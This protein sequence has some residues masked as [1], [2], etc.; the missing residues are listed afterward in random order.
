MS[1]ID[2]LRAKRGQ[3]KEITAL[4][5][6]ETALSMA[7]GMG[8]AFAGAVAGAAEVVRTGDIFE[9]T[10]AFESVAEATNNV[11]MYQPRTDGGKAA[12]KAV[13]DLYQEYITETGE[14]WGEDTL[15]A[16]GSPLLAAA[17]R[18]T[19]DALA[20]LLPLTLRPVGKGIKRTGKAA[21]NRATQKLAAKKPGALEAYVDI[22]TGEPV[23][24]DPI[25]YPIHDK[26]VS[27][28]ALRSFLKSESGVPHDGVKALIKPIAFK[29]VEVLRDW[30]SPTLTQVADSIFRPS[31]ADKS[32]GYKGVDLIESMGRAEG[33]LQKAFDEIITPIKGRFK[34][35]PKEA[36]L[37]LVR[38]LRTGKV[39]E[40]YAPEAMKMREFLDT[41]IDTYVR[42]V[43]ETPE[44]PISYLENYFPQVWD[45]NRIQ[46]APGKFREFVT[47][48]LGYSQEAAE[49]FMRRVVEN[50]GSPE[51]AFESARLTNAAD[52][53]AWAR[54]VRQPGGA[55]KSGNLEMQR[56]VEIP[57]EILPFAE[58]WLLNDLQGVM[59][60]YIR[61]ITRRV[62]YARTMGRSEGKLNRAVS[63][64]I[65]ELG[66]ENNIKAVEQLTSDVYGLA[67]ALQGKYRPIKSLSLAKWNRRL[68]NYETVLH[69][70]L[71]SLASFPEFTA[72]AIQFGFVPRAYARGV[73][74]AAN[75]AA[76][77][78]QRVLTGKRTLKKLREAEALEDAGAISMNVLQSSQ[79]SRF[80]NV[81]SR[82]TSRF[83]HLT[84]LE[85]LTDTQRVIA[86]ATIEKVIQKNAKKIAEGKS[87]PHNKGLLEELGLNPKEVVEWYKQG[88]PEGYIA[89]MV[90]NA[91]I[92]AQ[93]WAITAPNPA[94]KPLLF[95]DPHWTNV[96]LF[97]SFTSVFSNVFMKRALSELGIKWQDIKSPISAKARIIGGMVAAI[98]IAYYTQFLR[99]LI[100][101][102]E[103]DADTGERLLQAFDRAALSGSFT[104]AWQIGSPYRFGYTDSSALR[105]LNLLGPAVGDTGKMIDF[106]INN[107]MSDKKRAERAASLIPIVN[108]TKSSKEAAAEVIEDV[109]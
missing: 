68:A 32:K 43:M 40:K 53:P 83:M 47:Q 36:D 89:D 98:T 39:A 76:G 81:T 73:L 106:A 45:V 22:K 3:K 79:A 6:G 13:E 10:P 37:A 14:E 11:V 34:D 72:P 20:M 5:I 7:S 33:R 15:G 46:R 29:P 57:E 63:Q 4:G 27:L 18:T 62:E 103:N 16:T 84:G 105:L 64:A 82:F 25:E 19:P 80:S 8:G 86:Y 66:I 107:E 50:E 23:T 61:N 88:S 52:A 65:K 69:L 54:R 102:R 75:E 38:G 1:A 31:R 91:K 94:T 99:D 85:L 97:K 100:T 101:G 104:Y 24:V 42:P 26:G 96:L 90:E 77:A 12:L 51:M 95:S 93:R 109:F 71:V 35:V 56:K 74:H 67:D 2:D 30:N 108:I 92:R 21:L 58:E 59:T 17:A 70:G 9:F 87:K 48:K 41:V 44:H 78:A 28:E 55:S 49:N 60:S